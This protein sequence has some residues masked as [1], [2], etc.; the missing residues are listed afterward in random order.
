LIPTLI[1]ELVLNFKEILPL[2]EGRICEKWD[3]FSK[4]YQV[5]IQELLIEP[6]LSLKSNAATATPPRIIVI[7]GL[8]ECENPA[9]QCEL[10]RAIARS[11]PHIPYPL[12]FLIA[13][14]PEAHITDVF[15]HDA[16]LQR[17]VVHRYNLSNDLDA[18]MDIGNF[19]EKEFVDIR[20]VHR[21]GKR[22][23]DTWPGRKAISS[24]VERSSGHF[25]YAST[26]IRY[27]R[28]PKHR[29]D[30]RLEVILRLRRP[31]EGDR[32][33]AQLDNL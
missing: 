14:R 11:I 6:L 12:R 4:I 30:D 9:I 20:K 13:S 33:F 22:L 27:L 31:Q 32:P 26:V 29:P 10:L 15:D 16:D 18:D 21:L 5:Q 2:V 24:I 3:L 7:D 19:L 25:I 23:P 17:I 28:Y 8:D 1:S